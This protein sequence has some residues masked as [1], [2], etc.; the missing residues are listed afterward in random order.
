VFGVPPKVQPRLPASK[1][2]KDP[3]V[4]SGAQRAHT[5]GGD[6]D[7]RGA[8][9]RRKRVTEDC[10][11]LSVKTVAWI[12]EKPRVIA[13]LAERLAGWTTDQ[14]VGLASMVRDAFANGRC[15]K[16]ATDSVSGLEVPA[17][18][19]GC[20]GDRYRRRQEQ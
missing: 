17:V 14:Y 12:V 18:G 8:V 11:E 7:G 9:V 20:V 1:W 5:R 10:D 15:A 13:Y 6:V 16:I 3:A 19:R 2:S 4:G